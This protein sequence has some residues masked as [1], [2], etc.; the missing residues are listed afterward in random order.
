MLALDSC[1]MI[2]GNTVKSITYIITF[3]ITFFWSTI[4]MGLNDE[5]KAHENALSQIAT[6][7]CNSER[8]EGEDYSIKVLG[9]GNLE[10]SFFGKKGGE[11]NGSFVF[12]K[13]QWEGRQDVLKEH[14]ADAAKDFRRCKQEEL[15][16]L[17][18]S[19]L[20]PISEAEKYPLRIER[21]VTSKVLEYEKPKSKS[22]TGGARSDSKKNLGSIPRSKTPVCLSVGPG[23]TIIATEEPVNTCCHGG[24]CS[25]SAAIYSNSNKKVCINTE[26]WSEDALY[27]G[28]G[29]AKYTLTIK[30][31]N[32]VDATLNERFFSECKLAEK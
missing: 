31:K 9:D 21:C 20:P 28:G 19:Y 7:R 27:G 29:C 24:R 32:V 10:V 13:I 15:K 4:V 25:V 6:E 1:L 12:T 16:F 23:Q 30:Y 22:I 18:E 5:Q 17:R 14:Q 26:C 8:I 3:G 11:V 2:G